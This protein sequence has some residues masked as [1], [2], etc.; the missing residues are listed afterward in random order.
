MKAFTTPAGLGTQWVSG[1]LRVT[2]AVVDSKQHAQIDG[3]VA[4][5]LDGTQAPFLVDLF[6]TSLTSGRFWSTREN[7]LFVTSSAGAGCIGNN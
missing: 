2:G 4:R 1:A 3:L 7:R 6:F 5:E